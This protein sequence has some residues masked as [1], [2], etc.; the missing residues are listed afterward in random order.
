MNKPVKICS[1]EGCL[2]RSRSNSLC[3]KHYLRLFH[4]IPLEGNPKKTLEQRIQE[5]IIIDPDTGCFN[6]IGAKS[7]GPAG[8]TAHKYGYIRVNGKAVRAHRLMYEMKNGPI[9]ED[10][11]LRHTCDNTLCVNP[12]HLI[13][14]TQFDNMRD[15]TL[16]GRDYH[17]VGEKNHSKLTESE[18]ISIR[19]KASAGVPLRD[20]A[21]VYSVSASH[22]RNI[23]SGK[24]WAYLNVKQ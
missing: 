12:A 7:G 9:P 8:T 4:G 20:L 24:K 3:N 13:P 1:V 23:V 21:E 19:K 22:I 6:W 15:M 16:R 14:G 5:K 11:L 10:S 18:V 2:N 17:P